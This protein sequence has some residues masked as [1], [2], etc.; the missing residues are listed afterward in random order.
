MSKGI[1]GGKAEYQAKRESNKEGTKEGM[2]WVSVVGKGVGNSRK[3]L[4][5]SSHQFTKLVLLTSSRS[6]W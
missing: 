5:E 1:S 6:H 4:M 3:Y 2:Q